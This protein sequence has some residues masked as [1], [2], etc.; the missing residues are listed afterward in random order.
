MGLYISDENGNVTQY[1]GFQKTTSTVTNGSTDLITSGGVYTALTGYVQTSRTI[2]GVDLVDNITKSELL[3]ALNVADGAEVNTVSSVNSKTGA[4]VLDADDISDST[5]TNKFVTASEKTTWNAKQDALASGT[6]IKTVGGESLV[7]SGDVDT[8][9]TVTTMP[10]AGENYVGRKYLYNG[11]YSSVYKQY[12]IYECRQVATSTYN[13]VLI[14]DPANIQVGDRLENLYVN[15]HLSNG[16]VN[17]FLGNC[18]YDETLYIPTGPNSEIAISNCITQIYSGTVYYNNQTP[19]TYKPIICATDLNTLGNFFNIQGCTGKAIVAGLGARLLYL[20]YDTPQNRA[21][22]EAF[23]FTVSGAGFTNNTTF[24]IYELMAGTFGFVPDYAN[25]E[26]YLYVTHKIEHSNS[27]LNELFAKLPFTYFQYE[28]RQLKDDSTHRL[29][30]DTEKSTWNGKQD[31]LESGTNIKTIN[32]SSIVGSGD[33]DV[34]ELF[35]CTYGTT[36]YAEITTA[37]SN[38]KLPICMYNDRTYSFASHTASTYR[39]SSAQ[40]DYIRYVTVNDSNVWAASA[41]NLELAN[42]KV[43]SISSSSTDTQYPSA[44]LVYDQLLLK[45]DNLPTTSTAGQVL[46]STST[47]GTVQ[48]VSD[49]ANQTVVLGDND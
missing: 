27:I 5:T 33:L 6:N 16:I 29:V 1:S 19:L 25:Y 45:Q 4:V 49:I 37:I 23:H 36:T 28:L 48:W 3:T 12:G 47:A 44:K 21:L 30:T 2:A 11:T 31:A 8:I 38:G 15:T 43:T 14:N 10:T 24:N 20:Q 40:S 42:N 46:K 22:C 9:V 13:W 34:K 41:Y 17:T 39:F 7:G 35:Y 18:S 26:N 32:N